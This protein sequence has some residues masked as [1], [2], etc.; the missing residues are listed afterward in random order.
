MDA[1]A[2]RSAPDGDD[3]D[4]DDLDEDDLDE[5]ATRDLER[6][7]VLDAAAACY[8]RFGVAKTTAA[9]IAQAAGTSRATLYRRHG[10][11]E[12]LLLQVLTRE[13]EAMLAES[14]SRLTEIEH[15][16]DQLIEGMVFSI[17]QIRSRPV[18]SAVFSSDAAG[19]IA[20]RALRTSAM[21]R[22]GEIGVRPP[23]EP[24]LE[25]GT[26]T[27]QDLDDLVE[28]VLRILISYAAVPGHDE[29]TLDDVRRQL[30]TCFRPALEQLLVPV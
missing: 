2:S 20:A 24:A 17:E 5:D 1:M 10:T 22:L 28:W 4:G 11:H 23:L 8:L 21:R 29:L 7:A 6:E 30:T 26:M 13:S 16:A 3:L 9:D 14:A 25:A 27:E 19:W 12:E 18:H 15:P